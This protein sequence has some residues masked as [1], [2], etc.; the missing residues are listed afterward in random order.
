MVEVVRYRTAKIAV[1][2][3]SLILAIVSCGGEK[4]SK[5]TALS[6][7]M[8]TIRTISG[9]WER[10]AER[11]LGRIAAELDADVARV[12]VEG[13][14]NERELLAEQGREGVNLVFCVGGYPESTLYSVATEFPNTVFVLLPGRAQAANVAGI[15]FLSEEVGYLAGAVAGALASDGRAGLLRGAGQPWL[16]P[17]EEGY[18]EGFKSRWRRTRVTV[19]E[20]PDGVWALSSAGVTTSLYAADISEPGVLAAAHDAGVQLV[21]TDPELLEVASH[22]V[23]AAIDVDVAEAMLRVAREVRDRTFSGREFVFD[24]G[25]GVLDVVINPDLDSK[26]RAEANQAL[27][28]ARAE[29][30]AGLVEF[31]GLGL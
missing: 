14:A 5:E 27:E 10:A 9:R 12:R 18:V 16:E 13:L 1:A 20:G 8:L 6:V 19:R 26:A 4:P 29:I 3:M 23:V 22:S 17:L 28:D 15:H 25:S 7:R 11:G 30:T 21:V 2:G 31:D 24:L